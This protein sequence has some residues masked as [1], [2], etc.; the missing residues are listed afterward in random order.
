MTQDAR[1]SGHAAPILLLAGSLALAGAGGHLAWAGITAPLAPEPRPHH[2]TP[3]EDA[4]QGEP[5]EPNV[6]RPDQLIARPLF[7]ETRSPPV[8]AAAPEP[9]PVIASSPPEEGLPAYRL[10]GVVLSA[11]VRK[12]LLRSAGRSGQWMSQGERTSDGWSIATIGEDAVVLVR[13]DRAVTLS[14]E[15]RAAR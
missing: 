11:S 13:G 1:A 4:V 14:M 7:S 8:L 3:G 9:A 6:V 5:D 10:A 2:S 12:T 15:R